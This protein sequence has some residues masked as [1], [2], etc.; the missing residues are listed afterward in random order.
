MAAKIWT[1]I[2]LIKAGLLASEE[3]K[4]GFDA[5]MELLIAAKACAFD[6]MRAVKALEIAVVFTASAELSEFERFA[7]WLEIAFENE[8][9]SKLVA[10]A[11]ELLTPAVRLVIEV[12]RVLERPAT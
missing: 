2:A 12:A 1:A 4:A 6:W 8:E 9:E 10:L 3:T 7:I 11:M 5:D